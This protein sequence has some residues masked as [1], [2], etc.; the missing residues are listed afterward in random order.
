[1]SKISIL[2]IIGD[3]SLAGAPRHLLS[4]VENLDLDQFTIHV[5]CPPGPLAGEIR[6][7]HRHI[8]LDIIAMHSRWDFAAI[9]KIRHS[10]KHI[11]PDI[12]HVHGTRAGALGRLAAIGLNIPVIYTEHLWTKQFRM[13]S[14]ILTFFHFIGY[15]FLDLFTTLNI[16][17]SHAVKDFMVSANIS[18]AEKTKVIYNGI[19]PSNLKAKIFED[20]HNFKIITVGT[21]N[22]QKGV[23]F[24]ILA[25]PKILKEFSNVSL[26][27]VGDGPFRRSLE[28]EVKKKKLASKVQFSG[29]VP[30]IEKYLTKFDIYVQPSLSESFGLAITQAMSVGLPVI[31]T[32][33]GGIPEVVTDGKSGI[34][35][36][37]A[38]PKALADGIL[39]LL[40]DPE[41]A[42]K[43]G[44]MGQKEVK[45][46]FDLK[47]MIKELERTYVET[48][49]NPAFSE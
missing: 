4:I 40:R 31:A 32:N 44:E 26:D 20:K 7:L 27:I 34:L 25:M 42:K 41:K 14:R 23:Q 43:M 6:K 2:E 35:V 36:E 49:K 11:K 48:A 1:M 24:L 37:A 28:K 33:A 15:W 39:T 22:P 9:S 17:V 38:D 46:K 3:P 12:I 47:D 30:D 29:F 8:D 5:I 45:L 13:R 18:R 10:I 16:A 19:T 21:L